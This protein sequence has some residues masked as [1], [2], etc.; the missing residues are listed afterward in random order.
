MVGGTQPSRQGIKLS[1][2]AATHLVGAAEG[3]RIPHRRQAIEDKTVPPTLRVCGNVYPHKGSRS[4][5]I[6]LTH[7]WW[8]GEPADIGPVLLQRS[9]SPPCEGGQ[10]TSNYNWPPLRA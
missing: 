4:V 7:L 6:T 10:S 3:Q 1:F 5:G 9:A 8:A 2:I